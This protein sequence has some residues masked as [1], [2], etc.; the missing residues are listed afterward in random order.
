LAR[1]CT[2]ASGERRHDALPAAVGRRRSLRPAI[3]AGSA[4]AATTTRYAV[5]PEHA[6]PAIP[7]YRLRR[8]FR[9]SPNPTARPVGAGYVQ[10]STD[11]IA[12]SAV[13]PPGYSV[14][15]PQLL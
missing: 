9:S 12:D 3:A 14:V 7:G 4:S 1:P 11:R 5:A 10:R 15:S 8:G 6:R 2:R 13:D